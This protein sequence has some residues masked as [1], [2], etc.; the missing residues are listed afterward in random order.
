MGQSDEYDAGFKA[1]QA[2]ARKYLQGNPG[3]TD[4]SRDPSNMSEW[5]Q[6]FEAGWLDVLKP[7]N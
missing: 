3:Q 1:G 4:Y 7:T 6:G 2:A 5:D